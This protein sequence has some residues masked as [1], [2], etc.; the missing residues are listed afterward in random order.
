MLS[1]HINPRRAR[2]RRAMILA[3]TLLLAP[4]LALE[5]SVAAVGQLSAAPQR[6]ATPLPDPHQW[7]IATDAASLHFVHQFGSGVG[8]YVA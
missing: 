8:D 7:A 4:G 2:R 3:T 6:P 5:L 1:R